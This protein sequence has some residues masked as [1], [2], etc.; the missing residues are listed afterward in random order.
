MKYALLLPIPAHVVGVERSRLLL[1]DEAIG[2]TDEQVMA[3]TRHADVVAR[4]VVETYLTQ[5][6]S[7]R[8]A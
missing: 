2:L 6:G 8:A 7:S 1:G 5:V 3:M 4:I